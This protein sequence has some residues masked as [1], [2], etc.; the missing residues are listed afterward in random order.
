LAVERGE[1]MRVE[2][3]R[4]ET[5]PPPPKPVVIPEYDHNPVTDRTWGELLERRQRYG[6]LPRSNR[7]D[8]TE[9]AARMYITVLDR[10]ARRGEFKR[11][12]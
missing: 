12:V 5:I 10:R 7:C 1:V 9:G 8:F 2:Y 6:L 3:Q 4:E 11:G